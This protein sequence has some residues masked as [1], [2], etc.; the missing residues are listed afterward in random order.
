MDVPAEIQI[1]STIKPGS[2]FYFQ[3]E[4][5][6]SVKP[7]YFVVLNSSPL[8][9]DALL[10]VCAVT[11]DIKT[12]ERCE[13]LEYE[14]AT[15]VS[16]TPEDCPFLKHPSLFDCNSAIARPLSVLIAKLKAGKLKRFGAVSPELLEKL[17]EGVLA[18]RVVSR[19]DKRLI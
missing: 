19:K 4:S 16:A 5:F 15:L 8:V 18:S 13:R 12:I 6:R 7:H 17:R 1:K 3:E 2:V 10:L 11:I 9:A 14:P